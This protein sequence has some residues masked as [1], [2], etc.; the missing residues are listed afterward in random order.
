MDDR[1]AEGQRRAAEAGQRQPWWGCFGRIVFGAEVGPFHARVLC[2]VLILAFL[3]RF[4]YAFALRVPLVV[5]ARAYDSAAINRS[6][7]SGY[8]NEDRSQRRKECEWGE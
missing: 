5:D 3:L 7:G 6:E 4:G 8:P 1:C 2:A